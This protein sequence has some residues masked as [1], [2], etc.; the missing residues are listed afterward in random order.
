MYAAAE[1]AL[2][3]ET[4]TLKKESHRLQFAIQ[5]YSLLFLKIS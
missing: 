2:E 3:T 5:I 4:G 1:V